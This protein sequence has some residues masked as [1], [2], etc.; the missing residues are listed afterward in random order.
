MK[1]NPK[2][3]FDYI[4]KQKDKDTTYKKH[5]RCSTGLNL[6]PDLQKT[7]FSNVKIEI[8]KKKVDPSM[9][10]LQRIHLHLLL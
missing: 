2:V 3:L 6:A 10:L 4:N 7:K 9:H 5:Q 8:M 1:N